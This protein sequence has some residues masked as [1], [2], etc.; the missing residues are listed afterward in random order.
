M[1]YPQTE[2]W[3][4]ASKIG[5][6]TIKEVH[7]QQLFFTRFSPAEVSDWLQTHKVAKL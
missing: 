5:K 1:I 3:T 6:G 2:S 4:V 7:K